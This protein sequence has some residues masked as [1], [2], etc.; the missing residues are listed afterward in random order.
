[1]PSSSTTQE[2]EI[3]EDR[4]SRKIL[5]KM[6]VRCH[7]NGKKLSMV[8][9]ICHLSNGGK[10]KIRGSESRQK[11]KPNSRSKKLWKCGSRRRVPA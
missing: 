5:E 6:F 10:P 9:Y 3:R 7:L 4:G 8:E 1:M 11:T 2:S